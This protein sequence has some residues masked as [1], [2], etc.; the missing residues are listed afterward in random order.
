MAFSKRV[1]IPFPTK[2]QKSGV[3][4]RLEGE[5]RRHL[6]ASVEMGQHNDV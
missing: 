5:M 2:R 1:S 3:S 6:A 4:V